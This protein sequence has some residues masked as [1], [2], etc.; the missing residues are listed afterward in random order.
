[1]S[2]RRAAIRFARPLDGPCACSYQRSSS[3]R[4][5]FGAIMMRGTADAGSDVV[6]FSR[7]CAQ[8]LAIVS[9]ASVIAKMSPMHLRAPLPKGT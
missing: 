2:C 3:R 8:M 6:G 1:V 4:R 5:A 9:V 7:H